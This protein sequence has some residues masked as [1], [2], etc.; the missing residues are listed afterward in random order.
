MKSISVVIPFFNKWELTHSRL[1]EFHQFIPTKELEIILVD[2]ASTENGIDSGV[3]WWQK[4]VDRHKIRYVKNKENLGFGGSMNRGASKAEGDIIVLFS[5][6]VIVRG[7]FI[8]E[9]RSAIEKDENALVCGEVVSWAGGWNEIDYLGKRM[10]I[11]YANGWLLACTK[12]VWGSLDGFDPIYGKYSF[13]DI[14][15]SV[16]ALFLGYNLV[17]LYSK[18]VKHIGAQTAPYDEKRN[19]ITI[20]NKEKFISKWSGRLP[21]IINRLESG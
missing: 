6:D 16:Q 13:E 9:I 7:D 3:A 5:N 12:E 21:E 10:I 11:P 18:F 17:G 2:D 20:Q 14:D 19:A 4:H 1:Y 8:S 15:L